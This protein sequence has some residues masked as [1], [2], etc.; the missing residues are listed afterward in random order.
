MSP[1]RFQNN[2]QSNKG[3]FK[4]RRNQLFGPYGIG[5]VMP[6]PDGG[7]LMIS[8]LDAFPTS[9]MQEVDDQRLAKHIGVS[10]LLSPPEGSPIPAS[11]FPKWLY[12][13]ICHTM[14]ECRPNQ[15]GP[16]HCDNPSCKG[17]GRSLVPERFI[18]V[19]PEGH[20]DDFPILEW[21]HRGPV[22]SGKHTI[23]RTTKGGTAN[24]ADIVYKC[25]ECGKSRSLG[26]VTR[27]GALAEVGYRC[28]GSQ[29]WLWREDPEGC[30]AD[31]ED[32]MVVQR[33][34]TNVWYPDVF[35]SIY[36]PDGKD[37]GV[38]SF[39]EQNIDMLKGTESNDN[40]DM[41][42]DLLSRGN[43]FTK[44]DIKDA[45]LDSL[46][47]SRENDMSDGD[48]KEEEY[49]ILSKGAS[50]Q[51]GIFDEEIV[52]SG[53]YASSYIKHAI[54]YVGLVSTLRET[55]A[56]IG[57]SRL[58]PDHND[59]LSYETRR[60]QLSRNRRNWALGI[61]STGEGIFLKFNKTVFE[62]W[63]KTL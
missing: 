38:V 60:R 16:G 21:V 55:R 42:A 37:P 57:F 62:E 39:V 59:G 8:G 51:T 28:K 29:P 50:R 4:L 23:K 11:R 35:S 25:V 19:C 1:K 43:K 30:K 47:K 41:V 15:H 44:D 49:R 53:S 22:S 33:G 48:Y 26:G 58:Y 3:K 32:I 20:V 52:N 45:Y 34:G 31:P 46:S 63:L 9:V 24:L 13:P 7:S 56:L 36:I 17:R 6:C 54:E 40:L 18:V 10:R 14:Y 5:A 2:S 27:K 12:C 61:Q